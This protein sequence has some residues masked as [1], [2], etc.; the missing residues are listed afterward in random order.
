VSTLEAGAFGRQ[1]KGPSAVGS[2]PRRFWHL[3]W[4]LATTEWKLRF[5]GSALGYLW[6]LMRPLLM[7]SVLYVLFAKVAKFGGDG[8]QQYAVGLLLGLV[9]FTFLAEATTAG[10]GCIVERESLVRKIEFPRLAVPLSVVLTALFNLGLNLCVVMVFLIA[11]GGE[12]RWTWLELPVIIV[13]LIMLATGLAMLLSVAFVRYRDVRPIWD[14]LMQI[15]F[16]ATPIFYTIETVRSR[17]SAKVA[18]LFM[19]NPFAAL[20]QQA[21]HAFVDP[22]HSS[23]AAAIGGGVRLL[24]P[25]ALIFAVLVVGYLVF[26]RAAP[27][28]AEEL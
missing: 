26:R 4:A 3:T 16:Y 28:L 13:L 9:L 1:I 22:S 7:F 2:D 21:R 17:A 19:L 8:V 20:L 14:V 12:P 27:R 6:Q 24:I 25:L 5:F 15:G 11:S 23:A 10:V 18:H